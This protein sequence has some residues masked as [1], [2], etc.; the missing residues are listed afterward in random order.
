MK[1]DWR[2][3]IKKEMKLKPSHL[4]QKQTPEYYCYN[5]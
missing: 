5:N 4:M 3:Q 1:N 2:Q